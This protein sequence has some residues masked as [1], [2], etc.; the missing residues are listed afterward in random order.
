M[1]PAQEEGNANF[2]SERMIACIH[3][4]NKD[5][6]LGAFRKLLAGEV[7]KCQPGS[8]GAEG[9]STFL[10]TLSRIL[11]AREQETY[12]HSRRVS[13]NA[14]HLARE[15]GLD[16]WQIADIAR[17]GLM[18]DVGKVGV[19][20]TILLKPGAL[21]PSERDIMR[22][23]PVFGWNILKE[24][25]CIGEAAEIILHH[26]ERFDGQGYPQKLTGE[27]IPLGS[28][29]VAIAD[30]FDVITTKRPYHEPRTPDE[31][32]VEIVR[33]KGIQ[34]DPVI[35]ERFAS[36]PP[37]TWVRLAHLAASDSPAGAVRSNQ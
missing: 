5:I 37:A 29:I 27:A 4:A 30:T 10:L 22:Q 35:V 2:G 20:D 28:R 3:A 14:E 15:L 31:A 11:D 23:H 19:P 1:P 32:Y 34:F 6:G 33:G 26:H 16:S 7:E 13:L 25:E 17:A 24:L 36:Q 12:G 9:L 21:I 8:S 18:H